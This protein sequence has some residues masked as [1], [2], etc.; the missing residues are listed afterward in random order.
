MDENTENIEDVPAGDTQGESTEQ[1]EAAAEISKDARMWAML[2]HLAGLAW[3]IV[4]CIGGILGSLVLWQIKKD[5]HPFIDANGKEALNFQIS[6]LIYAVI[7]AGLFI[8]CIGPFLLA[9]VA[10]ADLI[11]AI[12]ASVKANNGEAYRYPVTI[13][14]I[15]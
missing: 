7:S 8:I 2:C 5:E 6:M 10:L 12:V 9:A 3:L 13:R 11:F 15:K 14:F 4:P 1:V